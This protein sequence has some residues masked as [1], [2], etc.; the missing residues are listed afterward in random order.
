MAASVPTIP[1]DGRITS[2]AVLTGASLVGTEVM[3]IVAPGNADFG[4]SYQITLESL[5]E[6][7]L[8]PSQ[9]IETVTSGATA[10]SPYLVKVND[11]RILFNKTIGAASFALL[12]LAA[13]MLSATVF[14]KDLKG[15]SV[16]NPITVE[17]TGGEL[18]DGLTSLEIANPY[19]WLAVSPVPGGGAWYQVQ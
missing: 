6:F 2:L 9:T 13:T 4:N 15:D 1:L 18:C 11:T 3:Y 10:G 14:V 8:S 19:G 17:F 5:A 12:P 7:F 16:T